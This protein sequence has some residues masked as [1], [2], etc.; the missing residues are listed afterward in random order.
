MNTAVRNLEA[1]SVPQRQRHAV[2]MG[3]LN[4]ILLRLEVIPD[5]A[6]LQ[7]TA[8]ASVWM[9]VAEFAHLERLCAPSLGFVL[10]RDADL[11]AVRLRVTGQNATSFMTEG[12]ANAS[13]Q[14]SS[15][16]RHRE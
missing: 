6:V 8:G 15:R 13:D 11:G 10:E 14:S 4:R 7:F 9:L 1:L 16:V 12:W 3:L 2:L 5:G